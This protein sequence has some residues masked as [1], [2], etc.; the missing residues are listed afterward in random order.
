MRAAAID[1]E[2]AVAWA[3]LAVALVVGLGTAADYGVTIDEF[4]TN[5]YGPKALAWY[6]SGFTDRSQFETVEFSLWYYGPWFQMI[7]AAVQ[8]LG[9]AEPLT[10]RHAMTF[11]V[12]LI[13]IAAVYPIGR[14]SFG[15]WVGACALALC[16]LTGYLYGNLFFA[17]IDIPFLATMCWALLAIMVMAR[18]TVPTWPA[19]VCAGMAIG[20]AIATRTGGIINQVYLIGMMAFCAVE[21]LLLVGT[22]ARRAIF[23]I[24]LRSCAA[25]MLAWI[26]AWVL[27]PWLQIGNPLTQF[28]IAYAHFVTLTADFQFDD[29]G[30]RLWTN[31]L[32]WSYIPDQWFA[33]LPIGFLALLALAILFAI[34]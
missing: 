20:L 18:T 19:T 1:Y 26:V 29:W 6:T 21:A 16:L 27:W 25:I 10:V 4:N 12:G 23:Q 24:V 5:D 15:S 31:A 13:G 14:L 22:V 32:P 34:F 3:L 11:V 28:K 7:T 9:L 17:P 33:R 8:S 30:R 2:R